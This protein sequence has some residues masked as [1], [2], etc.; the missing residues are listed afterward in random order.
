[1]STQSTR[2][3]IA[4]LLFCLQLTAG[5]GQLFGD[6]PFL[7]PA[8]TLHPGRFWACAGA[9]A[10]IYSGVSVALWH[11]WYKDYDQGPFHF[12]NDWRE[13]EHMDKMGH[14]FTTYIEANWSFQGAMW[15][16]IPRRKAMWTGVGIGILLQTTVEVMD[17]FSDKWGFSWYDY[18]ANLLGAGAFAGQEIAWGEQRIV[19]KT[20]NAFPKYPEAMAYSEDGTQSVLLRERAEELFGKPAYQRFIKDYNGQAIWATANIRSFLG[21]ESRFPKWLNLAVGYSAENLYAGFGYDFEKDGVRYYVAPSEYPRYSQFFLSPDIDLTRIPTR[22][23]AL[24]TVFS[25]LNCFKIPGPALEVTTL[26]KVRL[27]PLFW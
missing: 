14:V 5:K 12:F 22:S 11:S 16:G 6:M 15:T 4:I 18:G 24:K 26:G 7:Q 17:G 8:D 20:S 10:A 27:H 9:G 21:A 25:I 23:R 19:F 2:K 13:W 3:S 1:M